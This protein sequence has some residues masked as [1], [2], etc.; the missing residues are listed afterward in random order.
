MGTKAN[1]VQRCVIYMYRELQCLIRIWGPHLASANPFEGMPD[2][3][4]NL[5]VG[6]HFDL[7][8]CAFAGS[9][10]GSPAS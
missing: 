3:M 4:Q 10:G 8:Y 6:F 7:N 1:T 2:D 5:F 9:E